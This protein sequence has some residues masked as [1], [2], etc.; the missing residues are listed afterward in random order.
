MQTSKYV[1]V[2][3]NVRLVSFPCI[4]VFILL[5]LHHCTTCM[6]QFTEWKVELLLRCLHEAQD[7]ALCQFVA[8]QLQER[9]FDLWRKLSPVACHS[10]GYLLPLVSPATVSL[11]P[12]DE[13]CTVMLSKGLQKGWDDCQKPR[14]GLSINLHH[15]VALHTQ[16]SVQAIT[17]LSSTCG[18]HRLRVGLSVRPPLTW[19]VVLKSVAE[20]LRDNCSLTSF[21]VLAWYGNTE[22]SI[23]SELCATLEHNHTLETLKLDFSVQPTSIDVIAIARGL[24]A[25]TTLKRLQL[26]KVQFEEEEIESLAKMLASNATLTTLDLSG[27][28]ISS[29]GAMLL[30]QVLTKDNTSLARLDLTYCDIADVGAEHLA[31]ML[32]TNTP[33]ESLDLCDNNITSM[34]ITHLAEAL[35]HNT[36]LKVLRLDGNTL[37]EGLECLASALTVNTTVTI[38][39]NFRE[40]R[41][42]PP[43]PGLAEMLLANGVLQQLLK[44][45]IDKTEN[46][47]GEELTLVALVAVLEEWKE[48]NYYTVGL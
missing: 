32:K 2:G 36:T 21:G 11:E 8:D 41:L 22:G 23:G 3:F 4:H 45:A 18:V 6:L 44:I 37:F 42:P 9:E 1:L 24:T 20:N 19:Q 13:Q 46:E 14:S 15:T 33:L 48:L 39:H 43:P 35:K 17:Q 47:F 27:A 38:T 30:A 40:W 7:P 29:S 16:D 31:N 12:H 10:L 34:G 28:G 26:R 5:C 25:N